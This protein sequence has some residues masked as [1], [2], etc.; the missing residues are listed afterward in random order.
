[1]SATLTS[2]LLFLLWKMFSIFIDIWRSI[3]KSYSELC[4]ATMANV[5]LFNRRRGGEIS[6]VML[7]GFLERD[8]SALHEDAAFGLTQFELHLCQH[9]SRVELRGKE[10]GKL[11]YYFHQTW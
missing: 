8:S 3:V 1:M 6:K 5:I 11:H 2:L 10:A 7:N 9:F 4:K